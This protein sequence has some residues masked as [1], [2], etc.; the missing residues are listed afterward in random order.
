MG[1]RHLEG[2]G[3]GC[4]AVRQQDA[5]AS[6]D[7]SLAADGKVE[8]RFGCKET[9]VRRPMGFPNQGVSIVAATAAAAVLAWGR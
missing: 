3:E 6:E 4:G 1:L 2:T 9:T 7:E 8:K 5:A